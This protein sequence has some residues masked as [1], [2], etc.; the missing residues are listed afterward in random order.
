MLEECKDECHGMR[1]IQLLNCS[2]E[3]RDK[4][5]KLGA[6]WHKD[7][8]MWYIEC[9]KDQSKFKPWLFKNDQKGR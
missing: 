9:C 5:K 1:E 8:N 4:V 6:K 2:Y 3:D 7:W